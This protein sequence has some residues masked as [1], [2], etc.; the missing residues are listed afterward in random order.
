MDSVQA[1]VLA[2]LEDYLGPGKYSVTPEALLAE[3]LN[4]DSLDTIAVVMQLEQR[5]RIK[6]G[7]SDLEGLNTVKDLVEVC[8]RLFLV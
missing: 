3:D 8:R 6:I 2:E 7:E 4:L 1:Q 5:L